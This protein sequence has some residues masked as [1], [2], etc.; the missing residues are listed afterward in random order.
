MASK[1]ERCPECERGIMH[2]QR[3]AY[4][5]HGV[6]VGT[7]PALKCRCGATYFEAATM[8]AIQRKVKK[9]GL[10]E[11]ETKTKIAAVGN[12][13][14]VR[15]PKQIFNFLKLKKGEDVNITTENKHKIVITI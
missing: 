15:I 8:R 9:K 10:W 5:L 6:N 1:R 3:V 12:S 11:L 13:Y 2:K 4:K 14:A 7:Y